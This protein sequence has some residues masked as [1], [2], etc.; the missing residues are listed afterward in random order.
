MS[1]RL[2]AVNGFFLTF[3]AL[4]EPRSE[5]VDLRAYLAEL[6]TSH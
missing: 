1:R 6:D 4:A 3:S 5:E 2:A